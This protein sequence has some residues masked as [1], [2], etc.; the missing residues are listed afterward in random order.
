MRAGSTNLHTH[1]KNSSAVPAAGGELALTPPAPIHWL[2]QS[3]LFC[4]LAAAS[5]ATQT[6]LSFTLKPYLWQFGCKTFNKSLLFPR[7]K[8]VLKMTFTDL[9]CECS[10]IVWTVC[11]CVFRVSI[12]PKWHLLMSSVWK[13]ISNWHDGAALPT[14]VISA[15]LCKKLWSHLFFLRSSLGFTNI[16]EEK[17]E[18][19]WLIKI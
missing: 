5:T 4:T 9:N 14:A 17:C 18:S 12:W 15:D 8:S 1:L 11:V 19:L 2:W 7:W 13:T 3:V 16:T 6:K 10:L